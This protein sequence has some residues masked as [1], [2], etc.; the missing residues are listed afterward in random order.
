MKRL[1][2]LILCMALMLPCMG[3]SVFAEGENLNVIASIAQYHVTGAV[4]PDDG[5]IGIPVEVNTYIKGETTPKTQIIL[6]V[7]NT[8]T[9]RIGTEGDDTILNDLLDEGYIVV[10]LD[11][12][13]NPKSVPP[14]LDWSIQGIRDDIEKGVYLNGALHQKYCTY[15]LPAG[16][17][18]EHGVQYWS[19][20]EHGCGRQSGLHHPCL[21]Q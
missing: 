13:N 3:T 7:M 4:L 11:Y 14:D 15:V 21:E 18:I 9:Q 10:V 17:R 6:Y 19:I 1:L 8:N 2:C 16:Y 5:Y 20:D 12:K